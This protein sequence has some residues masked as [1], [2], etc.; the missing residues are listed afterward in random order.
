MKKILFRNCRIRCKLLPKLIIKQ[1]LVNFSPLAQVMIKLLL[2]K[3]KNLFI[4]ILL[5]KLINSKKFYKDNQKK[6]L[7][8]KKSNEFIN[9]ILYFRCIIN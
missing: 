2:K 4:L 9:F 5:I 8:N 1:G 7:F 3:R 6:A